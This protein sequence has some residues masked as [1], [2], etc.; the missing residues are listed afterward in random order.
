MQIFREILFEPNLSF[1]RAHLLLSAHIPPTV[2][3]LIYCLAP[4]SVF[5]RRFTTTYYDE[6]G[7]HFP[8][9]PKKETDPK[10]SLLYR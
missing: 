8:D 1:C 7:T 3:A 6:A 2:P 10:I 4:A 9:Y 5:R